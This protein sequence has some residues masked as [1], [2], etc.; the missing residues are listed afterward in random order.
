MVFDIYGQVILMVISSGSGLPERRSLLFILSDW[1]T[2]L[3]SLDY[4]IMSDPRLELLSEPHMTPLMALI[5]LWRNAGYDV[6]NPD[7]NDAGINAKALFLLESP[8]P[9]AVGTGFVSC[10][11]PDAS[12]Q[13][14]RRS[15]EEA[16]LKRSEV[17]LWNVVPYCVSSATKNKNA[18]TKDIEKSAPLTQEFVG[19]FPNLQVVVLCGGKAVQALKFLYFP[20]RV[21]ATYHT[22]GMAYNQK[23]KRKN[24]QETFAEVRRLISR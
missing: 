2:P 11:N 10:D 19:L 14:M 24:I 16:G 22:G 6:P 12:A 21:F 9:K 8:G 5:A 18:S 20:C 7:P 15:L 3:R 23:S 17:M 1:Q 13:N 4:F